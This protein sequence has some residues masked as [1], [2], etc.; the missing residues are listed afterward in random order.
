MTQGRG[1][2]GSDELLKDV[3]NDWASSVPV[4]PDAYHAVRAEW[5][6][7]QRRRKRLGVLTATLL[8]ALADVVGLWALNNSDTDGS[9]M[10]DDR[11][12]AER[13][14]PITPRIGQ[15]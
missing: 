6:R 14:E 4:S 12:P 8:V 7:R 2:A 9:M 5:V 3:L 11:P 1:A 15:P 13:Q 10:F